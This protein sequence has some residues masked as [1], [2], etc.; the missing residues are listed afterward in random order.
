MSW[1]RVFGFKHPIFSVQRLMEKREDK[2]F[3]IPIKTEKSFLKCKKCKKNN[4]LSTHIQIRSADEP[5]SLAATCY[6]CGYKWIK[7]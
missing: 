4:V 3:L 2:Y 7:H 5:M 6:S 1:F